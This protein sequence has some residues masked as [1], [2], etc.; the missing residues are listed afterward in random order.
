[1]TSCDIPIWQ[2]SSEQRTMHN[3]IINKLC[4]Y[5]SL[6]EGAIQPYFIIN[7]IN[8]RLYIIGICHKSSVCAVSPPPLLSFV[9][10]ISFSYSVSSVLAEPPSCSWG[11][12]GTQIGH[13]KSALY[14]IFF[15]Q[16]NYYIQLEEK[17]RLW[18]WVTRRSM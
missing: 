18:L 10:F 2:S 17:T 5:T 12:G 9:Y 15:S 1:M 7:Y 14:L 8:L 6:T 3:Y 4:D 13:I 16:L 11:G